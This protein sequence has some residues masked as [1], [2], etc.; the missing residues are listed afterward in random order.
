MQLIKTIVEDYEPALR[1]TETPPRITMIDEADGVYF[2]EALASDRLIRA[3]VYERILRARAYLP[4]DVTFMIY[5]AYRPVSRQ[6]ELWNAVFKRLQGEYPNDGVEI[7]R[8]RAKEWVSDPD[9]VGSGHLFAAA[10]DI[11]LCDADHATPLDMGC[12]VQEFG[13]KTA[14]WCSGLTAGQ[15]ANRLILLNALAQEGV[16]NYPPEWWHFSYG[17]RIWAILQRLEDT[18]YRPLS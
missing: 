3:E 10:V 1:E 11:T 4:T 18:L 15:K 17:D 8:E 6:R 5:E 16:L 12:E 7:I 13:D 14:T 9:G 2:N